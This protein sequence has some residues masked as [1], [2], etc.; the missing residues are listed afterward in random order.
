MDSYVYCVV[1]Y[2]IHVICGQFR[3]IIQVSHLFLTVILIF[4]GYEKFL[5]CEEHPYLL[6][7]VDL[8]YLN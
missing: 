6:V 2:H 4:L 5:Y 1:A 8:R 7:L 3:L